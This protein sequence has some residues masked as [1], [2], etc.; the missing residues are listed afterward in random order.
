M[1]D[2]DDCV[3]DVSKDTSAVTSVVSSVANEVAA[4]KAEDTA[5]DDEGMDLPGFIGLMVSLSHFVRREL[6]N[7]VDH[8]LLVFTGAQR[9]HETLLA[10]SGKFTWQKGQWECSTTRPVGS[11]GGQ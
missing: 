11:S 5:G 1:L 3:Q 8:Y 10:E 4:R 9:D 6:A 2:L 7:Q